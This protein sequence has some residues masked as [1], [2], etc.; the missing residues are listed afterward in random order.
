[1]KTNHRRGFVDPGSFRDRSMEKWSSR[2]SG[3]GTA[4]GNDFTKGHRG[5]AR[6]VSGAK[7]YIRQSDRRHIRLETR[8]ALQA[9]LGG[10]FRE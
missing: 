9:A 2:V 6:A 5:H 7:K 1:M 4:I 8:S 3:K 10:D